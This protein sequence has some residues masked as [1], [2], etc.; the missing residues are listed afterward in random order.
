MKEVPLVTDG[1]LF[2]SF[3]CFCLK[4][5]HKFLRDLIGIDAFAAMYRGRLDACHA[6]VL[7]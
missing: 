2:V 5:T 6:N 4:K 1:E 3:R 7:R